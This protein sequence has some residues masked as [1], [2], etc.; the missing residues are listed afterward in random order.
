M[1]GKWAFKP[2]DGMG[3]AYVQ[4]LAA[5]KFVLSYIV[6]LYDIT[7]ETSMWHKLW[8]CH[9]RHLLLHCQI[10]PAKSMK[11]LCCFS[12]CK[13]TLTFSCLVVKSQL[14][15][16]WVFS[17]EFTAPNHWIW[18][19]L[20]QICAGWFPQL[21]ITLMY[22]HSICWSHKPATAVQIIQSSWYFVHFITSPSSTQLATV[23][24]QSCKH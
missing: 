4:T 21:I 19:M 10:P 1:I 14:P 5:G 9:A 15:S 17:N 6:A 12:A 24:F 11:I 16:F 2:L 23:C 13:D 18:P 20:K 8:H 22:S 3:L 7:Y